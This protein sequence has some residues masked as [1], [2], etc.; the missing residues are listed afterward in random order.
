VLK[1]PFL[2]LFLLYIWAFSVQANVVHDQ[3]K[4]VLT[5]EL[6][7]LTGHQIKIEKVEG[8]LLKRVVLQNVTLFNPN[9]PALKEL[10]SIKELVIE[11]NLAKAIVSG[12]DFAA[13]IKK[14]ILTGPEVNLQR[15]VNK[16]WNFDFS[17]LTPQAGGRPP[18]LNFELVVTDGKFQI[19]DAYHLTG[20]KLA[21]SFEQTLQNVSGKVFFKPSGEFTA[22]LSGQWIQ[23]RTIN[24][25][26]FIGTAMLDFSKSNLELKTLRNIALAPLLNYVLPPQEIAFSDMKAGISLKLMAEGTQKLETQ[27]TAVLS[28]GSASFPKVF[29]FPV[30]NIKGQLSLRK[31]IL[32]LQNVTGALNQVPLV[33]NGQVNLNTSEPQLQIKALLARFD[34]GFISQGMPNFKNLNLTGQARTQIDI[35]GPISMLAIE[36]QFENATGN[37]Y[38]IPFSEL[39]GKFSLIKDNFNLNISQMTFAQ[40]TGVFEMKMDLKNTD[41]AIVVKGVLKNAQIESLTHIPEFLGKVD[42][43]A[44]GQG[45]LSHLPI[46]LELKTSTAQY[47]NQNFTALKGTV[48]IVSQNAVVWKELNLFNDQQTLNLT[49]GL[50]SFDQKFSSDLQST[51]WDLKNLPVAG[52]LLT[53]SF[54]FSGQVSGN[55]KSQPLLDNLFL[56]LNGYFDDMT[57][58]KQWVRRGQGELLLS[59][60]QW[61]F[62]QLS[63]ET[64]DSVFEGAIALTATE[65][66]TLK[67]LPR[68]KIYLSDITQLR[69]ALPGVEGEISY[70]G[71]LHGQFLNP[72]LNGKLK[73]SRVKYQDQ[74]LLD[75]FEMQ[76]E[77]VTGNFNIQNA[78][79]EIDRQT[80]EWSAAF[81]MG[82][83]GR[84]LSEK[85][86]SQFPFYFSIKTQGLKMETWAERLQ[87]L[88]SIF[89]KPVD[90]FGPLPAKAF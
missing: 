73:L 65:I 77:K 82:Q 13:S 86:L 81:E 7:K 53:G 80:L 5:S 32:S 4:N 87:T 72:D 22:D 52:R 42:L 41:P 1:K 3:L 6:S 39:E 26:I 9:E 16:N 29:S 25:L 31:N 14:I 57:F 75:L 59:Q 36:G 24:P 56:Q 37:L 45:T 27:L 38:E 62:N 63:L 48:A 55:L 8:N 64:G 47:F 49:N 15:G 28:Q 10:A 76:I 43:E 2:V 58:D 79:L 46:D 90:A 69:M 51:E 71:E 70:E 83:L 44:E 19:Q 35:T 17:N 20:F 61:N 33:V 54:V 21:R 12:G 11:F 68:T 84:F 23:D 89:V 50:F 88:Q 78:Q 40:G 85:R 34:L 18:V 67:V 60:G 66:K 30:Q 74:T